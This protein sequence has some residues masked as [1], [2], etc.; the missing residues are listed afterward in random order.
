M[1]ENSGL[2]FVGNVEG[3]IIF[4][5]MADLV[6]CDG[7]VG[8]VLLKFGESIFSFITQQHQE[9]DAKN[10]ARTTGALLMTPVFKEIKK[11][12]VPRITAA[13]LSWR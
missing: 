12:M 13:R 1:L 3:R 7:F 4:K 8:N 5:G 6:V 10:L 11:E 2:N 9:K